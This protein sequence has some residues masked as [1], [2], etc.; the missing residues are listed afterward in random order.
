MRVAAKLQV[1]A[2]ARDL[3]GELGLVRKQQNRCVGR[4]EKRFLKVRQFPAET[5]GHGVCEP[6]DHQ[7]RPLYIYNAVSIPKHPYAEFG[8]KFPPPRVIR[9]VL[10]I[11]VN[12]PHTVGSPKIL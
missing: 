3:K 5:R 10:M 8:Q 11:A 12:A 7:R 6:C 4:T 9:V 2:T 1:N